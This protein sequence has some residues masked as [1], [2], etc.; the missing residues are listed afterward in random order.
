MERTVLYFDASRS[1]IFKYF[2]YFSLFVVVVAENL[3]CCKGHERSVECVAV[4]PNRHQESD[5]ENLIILLII[6][7]TVSRDNS[8]DY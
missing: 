5:Q 2:L 7:G 8:S 1:A 4:S 6:K 3:N